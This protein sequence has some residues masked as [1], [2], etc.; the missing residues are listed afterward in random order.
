MRFLGYRWTGGGS[1][2][3]NTPRGRR[4]ERDLGPASPG[5]C[6][7]NPELLWVDA[8]SQQALAALYISRIAGLLG[9]EEGHDEWLSRY[10]AKKAKIN[11]LYW[12]E[13][14]GFYYDILEDDLSK[15]KVPT[16]ASYWTMLAEVPPPHRRARKIEKLSD[17]RWFGGAVPTPSLARK[18]PDFWPTGGSA[19]LKK[20]RTC[21]TDDRRNFGSRNAVGGR[22]APAAAVCGRQGLL[23]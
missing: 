13:A 1:G 19:R 20:G 17:P 10:A 16:I 3:D 18:D 2:M 5:D 8:Y 14:D 4:G 11:E 12:D 9:D 6:P 22:K 15:C 21:S 7:N 23:V